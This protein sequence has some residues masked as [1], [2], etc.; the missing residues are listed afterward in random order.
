M[1]NEFFRKLEHILFTLHEQSRCRRSFFLPAVDGVCGIGFPLSAADHSH[2]HA[3]AI[4]GYDWRVPLNTGVPGL[5]YAWDEVQSLAV[6]DDNHLPYMKIPAAPVPGA[7]YSAQE[8]DL[9]IVALPEKIFYPADAIDRLGPALFKLG[10]A[11]GL[12]PKEQTIIRYFITTG[13][14]FAAS[15]EKELPSSIRSS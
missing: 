7:P 5:R 4:V 1:P 9:F 2:G 6:V 8:I 10:A 15:H 11:V 14:A 3:I 13:S 12:P